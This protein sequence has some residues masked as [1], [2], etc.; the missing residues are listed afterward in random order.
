MPANQKKVTVNKFTLR[1]IPS[2][3][4]AVEAFCQ[5]EGVSLNHFINVAVAE[6][7]ARLQ[8]EK[9]QARRPKA[10]SDSI[11]NALQI[12]DRPTRHAPEEVDKLPKG[13]VSVRRKY[14]GKKAPGK[15]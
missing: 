13:Y 4:R 3:R 9:W 8:Q 10:S 7:L 2:V 15:G 5:K 6:K 11:A 1:L 14:S 12:L